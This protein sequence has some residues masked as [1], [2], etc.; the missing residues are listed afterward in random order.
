MVVECWFRF[1]QCNS[2]RANII[3]PT[4]DSNSW[5]CSD[6]PTY[7]LIIQPL[8]LPF[9]CF[10]FVFFNKFD[11]DT[12]HC[13]MLSS[14]WCIHERNWKKMING[15]LTDLCRHRIL[16]E[17]RHM[18]R[19]WTSRNHQRS[20]NCDISTLSTVSQTTFSTAFWWIKSFVFW[21]KFHFAIVNKS[22]LVKVMTWRRTGYKA[23]PGK[24]LTQFTDR[25]MQY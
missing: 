12:I 18:P 17:T 20:Q 3:R 1:G 21:F 13:D 22:V 9:A 10:S 2:G 5:I 7:S 11:V 14:N 19:C 25:Y 4:F 23:L 15:I 16:S 8:I 24:L 6:L